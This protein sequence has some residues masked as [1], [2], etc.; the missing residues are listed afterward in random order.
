MTNTSRAMGILGACTTGLL[1]S[2]LSTALGAPLSISATASLV[3][4]SGL[5][6]ENIRVN[7]E[8]IGERG[9]EQCDLLGE[10]PALM[11]KV[12]LTLFRT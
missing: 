9:A 6:A 1:V 11:G 4:T 12:C 5:D 3:A 10:C 8:V 2:E 7:N